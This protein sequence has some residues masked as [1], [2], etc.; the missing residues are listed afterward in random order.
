MLLGCEILL[1][2]EAS[3]TN[4][5]C[6]LQ[7]WIFVSYQLLSCSFFCSPPIQTPTYIFSCSSFILKQATCFCV[8]LHHFPSSDWK[9]LL[10]QYWAEIFPLVSPLVCLKKNMFCNLQNLSIHLHTAVLAF[11]LSWLKQFS[12]AS[13]LNQTKLFWL[14]SDKTSGSKFFSQLNCVLE[15]RNSAFEGQCLLSFVSCVC[16]AE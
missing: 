3:G 13:I 16:L 9:L 6:C 4:C 5:Y 14:I 8:N 11:L 7:L 2:R 10:I 15:T 1:Y 12:Y